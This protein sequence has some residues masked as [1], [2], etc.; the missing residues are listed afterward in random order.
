MAAQALAQVV[1]LKALMKDVNRLTKDERGPLFAAMKEAGYNA[2]KPVVPAA[3]GAL[4]VSDRKAGSSHRPGALAGSLRA[5]AYR[6]GAAVRMGSKSVPY[7]GW[8]EF[9][10][11]RKRPHASSRPFLRNGRYLFPAAEANAPRAVREYT[12][13]INRLFGKTAIWT[14]ATDSEG[15]I[16]D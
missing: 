4:P 13:S 14:N 10:G 2:V 16:H 1:G 15:S 8:V 9:G 12:S 7:A 5:S 6:S 11:T 3:R